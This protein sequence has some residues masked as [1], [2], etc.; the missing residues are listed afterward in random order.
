M[1]NCNNPQSPPQR[2]VVINYFRAPTYTGNMSTGVG[3]N[4]V[5]NNRPSNF[6]SS[7]RFIVD[8]KIYNN[9]LL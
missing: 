6:L 2:N 9:F 5:N 4:E 7:G 3:N 8:Q 1:S